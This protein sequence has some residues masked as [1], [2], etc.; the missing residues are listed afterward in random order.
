MEPNATGY[1]FTHD[2]ALYEENASQAI[3]PRI[4]ARSYVMYKIG[5]ILCRFSSIQE[6]SVRPGYYNT[7]K[8]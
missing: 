8:M 6:N 7:K 4:L 3:D 5:K 2:M 1:R